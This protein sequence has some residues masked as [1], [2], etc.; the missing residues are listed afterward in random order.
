VV[1]IFHRWRLSPILGSLGAGVILGPFGWAP[2]QGE[3][4]WLRYF[5]I[6]NS[7]AMAQLAEFGVVFLLSAIG[8]ELS[9]ERL[10]TMHR[11]V[12]GL[13]GLQV[14]TRTAAIAGCAPSRH[15]RWAWHWG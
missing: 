9:W 6:G 10:W 11:L 14:V 15:S 12:F 2:L 13:G 3:L 5:T 7:A 8:L 4:P 1:P